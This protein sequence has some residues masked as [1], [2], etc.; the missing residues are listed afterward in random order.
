MTPP[1][2]TYRSPATPLGNTSLTTFDVLIIGSGAGGS[3]VAHMLTRAGKKVLMLEAGQNHFPGLDD[4]TKAPSTTF[5]NDELKFATRR[6]LWPDP[7]MEPQT[8]R[9][10]PADGERTVVGDVMS[11]PKTV[12]GAAV[13]ADLKAPR[14]MKDDFQRGTLLGPNMTS[15]SWADWPLGYD[16]LE[17]FYLFTERLIGVQGT[18][19]ANPFEA[20]RSAP[21]PMPPG[22]PMYGA[23]KLVAGAKKLGLNPFPYPGAVTSQPYDGRPACN[24]CG[25]CTSYGCPTHAKGAPPVTALRKALLTNNCLLLPETRATKLLMNGAKNA[26]VGVEALSPAGEKVTYTA[27]R[28]V[29]AASPIEDARL[30]MLSSDSN[31]WLGNSS[32]QVGRN[33]M[34]H[35]QTNAIAVFEERVHGHRG[36]TVTHGICDF[37]G[38]PNDPNHPLG[39]IVEF[40]GNSDPVAEAGYYALLLRLFGPF[41]GTRFRK[42]MQQSPVRDHLMA[43][44]MQAEDAPQSKN[45]VDLDPAIKDI[46][47]LPVPRI[48]YENHQFELSASEFYK[49][50]LLDL[51]E[52][53]GAKWVAAAPKDDIPKTSHIMGTLR[54][55]TDPRTS[56]CDKD[57][58]FHDIGNLY[59]ADGALFPSSGG[60][61][62]TLTIMTLAVRVGAAM[63]NAASPE[64]QL[65]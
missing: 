14:F 35:F 50:K 2:R 8:W 36:R 1:L 44:A 62:P 18:G 57:G 30:L 52:A 64:Q 10:S 39:G 15:A 65:A 38:V 3:S 23:L 61:N 22:V 5:S 53:S 63:V 21:F 6:L 51:L 29:L 32:D 20:P 24:D 42:L 55:G 13:L 7:R 33:I 4:G 49:P 43:V 45:R 25:F 27:D 9:N 31:Q 11:L 47:G 54:F 46:D 40:S 19:G 17:K 59:C 28:Y 56:V 16:E 41:Q 34:F 12:G 26:V 58:R 37:R 60:F 48:T